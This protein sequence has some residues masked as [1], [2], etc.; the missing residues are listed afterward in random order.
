V[1]D[2]RK[3]VEA[4]VKGDDDRLLVVVGYVRLPC[5]GISADS[6]R[7]CSVHDPEQALAYCKELL[8]YAEQ[9]ADDLLIVMRVY[10]E[11]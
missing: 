8:K 3:Q 7:P 6:Q 11:K 5:R 1:L 10:F 9:A 4:V 2:A